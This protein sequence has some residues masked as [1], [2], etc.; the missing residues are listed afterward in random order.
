VQR[1]T[2]GAP[3]FVAVDPGH[4]AGPRKRDKRTARLDDV[5]T[6]KAHQDADG[7]LAFADPK[8]ACAE[9]ME[10]DQRPVQVA[11][12]EIMLMDGLRRGRQFSRLG[13]CDI[14][15]QHHPRESGAPKTQHVSYR[16]ADLFD[17]K[18]AQED[19]GKSRQRVDVPM[20]AAP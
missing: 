11:H 5:E 20:H 16:L 9:I 12:G 10:S 19:A 2:D 14:P 7:R 17:E 4:G 13:Q 3:V 15:K 1:P 18:V 8:Q 6:E